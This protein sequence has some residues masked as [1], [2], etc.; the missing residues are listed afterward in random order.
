MPA[1]GR[2]RYAKTAGNDMVTVPA[3]LHCHWEM[4][5]TATTVDVAT[6]SAGTVLDWKINDNH[7]ERETWNYADGA[8]SLVGRTS[9]VSCAAF[10]WGGEVTYTPPIVRFRAQ[11]AEG[12]T[13]TGSAATAWGTE[14][15]SVRVHKR[16]QVKVAAGTFDAWVV[17]QTTQHD[18]YTFQAKYTLEL[19]V[20]PS[21]G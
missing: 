18:G 20:I 2:Y 19:E 10:A 6:T 8:V 9:S 21:Q 14:S 12:A 7:T 13:G 3:G 1:S 16:E 11:L 15:S 5:W 17:E 4:N